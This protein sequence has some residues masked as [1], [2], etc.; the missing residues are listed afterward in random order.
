MDDSYIV[1]NRMRNCRVKKSSGKC[2]SFELVEQTE[3]GSELFLLACVVRN[4][5]KGDYIFTK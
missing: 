5:L 3:S 2:T 4:D 1:C